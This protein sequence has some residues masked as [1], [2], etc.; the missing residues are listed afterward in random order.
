MKTLLVDDSRY[1]VAV[2]SL[3][4]QTMG[5][6]VVVVGN[7]Q[8]A[9]EQY[10]LVQPDIVLMDVIMPTMDGYE[11]ARELRRIHLDWVP[12][13]FLSS[14]ID[15]KDIVAGINS[16]GDDYLTK[17]VNPIVLEAKMIAMQRIATMRHKLI[18][19]SRELEAA[20]VELKQLVNIDGLTG[21]SNRRYMDKVLV[22]EIA[23]G[24]RQSEPLTVILADVDLFKPYNDHYGH[25]AGDECLRAIGRVLTSVVHR[26]GD[27]VARY[28][29]EEFAM[30]LPNTPID[31]AMA[32]AE[33]VR[34]GVENLNI[35]HAYSSV[36]QVC[37]LSAGVYTCLPQSGQNIDTVLEKADYC[38]Y[39]S[40][41]NGR[42]RVT[43]DCCSLLRP[44]H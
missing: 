35:P 36:A 24:I 27:V 3:H 10:P 31:G 34:I 32:I 40:K 7:G 13:I 15:P 12:I 21:L 37:T 2:I 43:S 20:N 26:G 14:C 41:Q 30:I 22:S 9:I 29:G 16:G 5:H 28:G 23:R 18:A 11:A 6:E 25:V 38:L 4:L 17:P 8:Q 33:V 19:V 39:Q 44:R 42:N 1:E